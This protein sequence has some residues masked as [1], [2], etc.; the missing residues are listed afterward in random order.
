MFFLRAR[1]GISDDQA[2][3]AADGAAEIDNAI[4]LSNLGGVFGRRASKN[5][6][7]RGRPPVM[8]LVFAILRGVF[9]SSVPA[10]TFCLP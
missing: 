10:S 1:L 6:A 5:S 4:D 3:L 8:S 2:A 7:T 9:A